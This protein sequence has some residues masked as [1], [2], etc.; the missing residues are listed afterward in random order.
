MGSRNAEQNDG[1]G[2]EAYDEPMR[3]VSLVPSWTETLIEAN[4]HVI[5]R[6]RFCIH[7]KDEIK[8]IP[9]IGG[10]KDL[11]ISRLQIL[12]PDLLVLDQEENLPWMKEQSP[13]PVHVSHVTTL[14]VM[15]EELRKLAVHFE[16]DEKDNLL[17]MAERWERV[18]KAPSLKWDFSKIP[19]EIEV[20]SRTKEDFQFLIYV[21]WKNPWMT[22]SKQTFIGSVLCKLGLADKLMDFSQK[23]PSIDLEKCDFENTYFLFSSEPFPFHKQADE[24]KKMSLQ[25]SIIN[26]EPFSW[27]GIRSLLFLEKALGIK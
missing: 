20:L 6:T 16:E 22:V 5:G 15:A 3:V 27:F 23:Y 2:Q 18:E 21:I 11:D 7:P 12:R 10:T 17:S 26:G 14:E 13:V 8:G 9:A 1:S 19:E 25:G 4:V 24:L